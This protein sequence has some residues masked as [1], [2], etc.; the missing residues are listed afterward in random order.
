MTADEVPTSQIKNK[1]A[2]QNPQ[3]RVDK[4]YFEFTRQNC[5]TVFLISDVR[6]NFRQSPLN[7]KFLIKN[8]LKMQVTD[9]NGPVP[10]R[11][12]IP[13]PKALTEFA[14]AQNTVAVPTL[15]MAPLKERKFAVLNTYVKEKDKAR[16][17]IE[18]LLQ[19]MQAID[20]LKMEGVISVGA[21]M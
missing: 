2:R 3:Q 1:K 4:F 9:R 11:R 12:T 15:A 10:Q 16:A 13:G 20:N 17:G 7:S 8:D 5:S 21:S 14:Q 19:G 6:Q 18:T